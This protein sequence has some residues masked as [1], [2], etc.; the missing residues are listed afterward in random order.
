[1]D[2]RANY[3]YSIDEIMG[4]SSKFYEQG[5]NE[6]SKLSNQNIEINNNLAKNFT[7]NAEEYLKQLDLEF[8]EEPVINKKKKAS[9]KL[10]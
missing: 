4:S 2:K 9:L 10:K 5:K 3:G 8:D 7:Q 1:M 6:F